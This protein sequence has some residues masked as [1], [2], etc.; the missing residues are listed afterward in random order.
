MWADDG[1]TTEAYHTISTPGA[2]GSGELKSG[3]FILSGEFSAYLK[4]I[5]V[6]LSAMKIE[7]SRTSMARTLV[8]RLPRLFPTRS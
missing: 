6:T 8:A 4:S 5:K 3:Y 7:Y 2:F 1:R